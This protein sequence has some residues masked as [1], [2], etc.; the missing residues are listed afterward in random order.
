MY[1]LITYLQPFLIVFLGFGSAIAVSEWL[2][3]RGI[4]EWIDRKVAHFIASLVV[5]TFPWFFTQFETVVIGAVAFGLLFLGYRLRLLPSLM[6]G[7]Q[8][9]GTLAFPIGLLLAAW[10]STWQEPLM[11]QSA[12]LIVGIADAVAGIV[13]KIYGNKSHT[14]FSDKSKIGSATFLLLSVIVLLIT[15]QLGLPINFIEIMLIATTLTLCE[16]VSKYGWDNISVPV[17][18][19]LM[20][21]YWV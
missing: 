3:R 4:S 8:A 12:V 9:V 17:M 5:L 10:L 20:I 1:N 19:I 13:G 16:A 18:A 15:T 6:I 21:Q 14:W 7:Y 2:F 11:F